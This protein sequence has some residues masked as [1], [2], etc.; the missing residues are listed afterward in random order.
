MGHS[1][2]IYDL[3]AVH[4]SS[5]LPPLLHD[6]PSWFNGRFRWRSLMVRKM[7]L[8]NSSGGSLLENQRFNR[9]SNPAQ[10]LRDLLHVLP[11]LP[12]LG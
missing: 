7:H 4:D 9:G 2:L 10:I 1:R 11:I 5:I 3:Y 12:S 8:F 6:D